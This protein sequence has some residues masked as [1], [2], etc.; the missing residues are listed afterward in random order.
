MQINHHKMR[1][2]IVN[3]LVCLDCL[4]VTWYLLHTIIQSRAI[5][6][7]ILLILLQ[8]LED[9]KELAI[10]NCQ[11]V[12]RWDFM[13]PLLYSLFGHFLK[14]DEDFSDH[15]VLEKTSVVRMLN[16]LWMASFTESDHTE[17]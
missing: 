10:G 15:D 5:Q 2:G 7:K 13:I 1:K 12:L 4:R 9:V 8:F 14:S 17:V 3:Y 6:A 11:E 16:L